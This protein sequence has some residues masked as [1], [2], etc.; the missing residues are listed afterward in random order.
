M[1][2]HRTLITASVAMALL[3]A[4]GMLWWLPPPTNAGY[5]VQA[6]AGAIVGIVWYT[7]MRI[8]RACCL[9]PCHPTRD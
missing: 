7:G 9:T 3:W 6:I 1:S 4:V 5:V 8:W 2:P